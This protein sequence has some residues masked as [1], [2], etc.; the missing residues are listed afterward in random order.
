ML[1]IVLPS[2]SATLSRAVVDI[3][4]VGDVIDVLSLGNIVD[5]IGVIYK[6]IVVVDGDVVASPV[7]MV[8]P[9]SPQAA[10]IATPMPNE[11]AIPAT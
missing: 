2:V 3:L 1:R 4:A 7:G 6:I 10:P 5:A 8:A 9:A 11:I